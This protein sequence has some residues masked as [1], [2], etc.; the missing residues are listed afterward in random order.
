[1]DPL[2]AYKKEAM[3]VF[4]QMQA[5]LVGDTVRNVFVAQLQQDMP[6]FEQEQDIFNLLQQY[7]GEAIPMEL[8]PGEEQE[9]ANAV[10]PEVNALLAAAAEAAQTTTPRKIDPN[11]PCPC[12]S[13]KKYKQCHRGKPLPSDVA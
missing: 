5:G 9:L 1:V 3:E 12:G 11:D 7:G 13:G 10:V 8:N 4:S 6:D 2:V